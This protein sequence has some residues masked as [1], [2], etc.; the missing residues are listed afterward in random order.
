MQPPLLRVEFTNPEL[1]CCEGA[2]LG[3]FVFDSTA[4]SFDFS[5]ITK[6]FAKNTRSTCCALKWKLFVNAVYAEFHLQ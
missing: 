4:Y 1:S 3:S 5:F 6:A 2:M